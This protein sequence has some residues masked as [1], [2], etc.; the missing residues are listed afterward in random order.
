M[1]R[2]RVIGFVVFAVA[3]VA[4]T[5]GWLLA[6][7]QRAAPPPGDVREVIASYLADAEAARE[8]YHDAPVTALG[9]VDGSERRDVMYT[10]AA[11][12]WSPYLD[13]LSKQAVVAIIV[14]NHHEVWANFGAENQREALALRKGE[15]V[16]IKGR[17]TGYTTTGAVYDGKV[18]L[19]VDGCEFIP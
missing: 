17:H 2:A 3:G 9:V 8:K 1:K 16:T 19:V 14:D 5:A 4:G 13:E 18:V 6:T 15:R 12:H 11:D 10:R 7:R